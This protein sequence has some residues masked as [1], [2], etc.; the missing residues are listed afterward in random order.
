[1]VKP[2]LIITGDG[3]NTLYV[4]ELDEHYHS[5]FGAINESLLVFIESGFQKAVKSFDEIQV[6]E[7]GFGTGLNALLTWMEAE[8]I[9]IKVNYVAI[10][11]YPLDEKIW[12]V[13]NYPDCFCTFSYREIYCRLHEM[14]WERDERISPFFSI[15]KIRSRLEDYLPEPDKFNLVYFDAFGPDVQPELWTEE[16]FRKIF[17]SM[18]NKGIL[19]TYSVKGSVRRALKNSGFSV[20]K[21]PGP[22]GK[23]EIT[24]AIKD[25]DQPV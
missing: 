20:E 6:L 19:V 4:P 23:R 25:G 7:I 16:I 1:M 24:R 14:D 8:R 17:L 10:E 18:K 3:S 13:L 15:C 22:A 12:S 21:L 11:P 9:P 5:T 2:E